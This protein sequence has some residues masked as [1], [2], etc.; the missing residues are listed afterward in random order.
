MNNK[1]IVKNFRAV[2]SEIADYF[3]EENKKEIEKRAKRIKIKIINNED[4]RYEQLKEEPICV[5]RAGYTGLILSDDMLNHKNANNMIVHGLVHALGEENFIVDDKD[6]FNEV[7]VDYISNEICKRLEEKDI[8]LGYSDYP[9][10]ESNSLYSKYFGMIENFFVA[11][12]K[13][14][15]KARLS[16]NFKMSDSMKEI[17][18]RVQEKID[19]Y[20]EEKINLSL[21]KGR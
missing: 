21:S 15:L 8:N 17:I 5:K 2:I 9:T 11:N 7:V 14:I 6:Y 16:S 12:K 13:N 4:P 19:S 18:V 20:K 10:Y 1:K 3:G